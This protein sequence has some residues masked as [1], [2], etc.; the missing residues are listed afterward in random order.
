MISKLS[1]GAQLMI[2]FR[3]R[4]PVVL[5]GRAGISIC[6]ATRFIIYLQ[7]IPLDTTYFPTQKYKTPYHATN[8]IFSVSPSYIFYPPRKNP[9]PDGGFR[10]ITFVIIKIEILFNVSA[11]RLD[12]RNEIKHDRYV[13][14]LCRNTFTDCDVDKVLARRCLA[15][16]RNVTS[17][18]I[19][20]TI[21]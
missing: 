2:F 20:F 4:F 12:Q 14:L 5:F 15:R 8:V 11:K 17:H 18:G 21:S 6:H 7:K 1:A 9:A 10:A 16:R 3:F 13:F 19:N